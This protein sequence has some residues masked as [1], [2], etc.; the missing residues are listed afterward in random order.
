MRKRLKLVSDSGSAPLLDFVVI[1]TL[2]VSNK[3]MTH[4]DSDWKH[5]L[6]NPTMRGMPWAVD[7]AEDVVDELGVQ[8]LPQQFI[9]TAQHFVTKF[10]RDAKYGGNRMATPKIR[11]DH[12][13]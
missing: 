10:I 9:H 8:C 1:A 7:D 4:V 11:H 5:D 6:I 13:H 2:S 12:Y 3:P